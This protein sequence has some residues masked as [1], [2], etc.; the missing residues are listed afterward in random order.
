[1][2]ALAAL[3]EACFGAQ[4][5]NHDLRV[6]AKPI[7]RA[8]GSFGETMAAACI[9]FAAAVLYLKRRRNVVLCAATSTAAW[10]GT[11][12]SLERACLIGAMAGLLL[13]S[14]GVLFKPQRRLLFRLGLLSCTFVIVFLVQALPTY[15]NDD[16]AASTVK[17]FNQSLKQDANIQVRFLY[18]GIAL[19][20][21]RSHPLLGVGGNNYQVSFSDAREQFAA[22]L[23]S[24]PANC[25]E[26]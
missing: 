11:L 14:L 13:L 7:L 15:S 22:R 16:N 4:V 5:T 23:S 24:K 19:E 17:R 10:L 26:R 25:D 2:L 21:L 8:S 20:M 9:L 3:I 6:A 18:W 12:L 1:M